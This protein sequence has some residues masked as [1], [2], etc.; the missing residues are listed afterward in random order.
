MSSREKSAGSLPRTAQDRDAIAV[1]VTVLF[2]FESPLTGNHRMEDQKL[3]LSVDAT[4]GPVTV[5]RRSHEGVAV[6]RSFAVAGF[7]AL[8]RT[9][10]WTGQVTP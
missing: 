3:P 8:L 6:S 5:P 2:E 7:I 10:I 1:S 9:E 4:L